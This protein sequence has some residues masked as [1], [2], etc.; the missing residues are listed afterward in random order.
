MSGGISMN[1]TIRIIA[2]VILTLLLGFAARQCGPNKTYTVTGELNG[3]KLQHTAPRTHVYAYPETAGEEKIDYAEAG[4][5]HLDVVADP[6]P[7]SPEALELELQARLKGEKEWS[8]YP[9]TGIEKREDG[10]ALCR[11][12]IPGYPWVTRFTY[13]FVHR[14][15]PAA[16]PQV[17]LAHPDG[18]RMTLR[19]RGIVPVPVTVIHVLAMFAGIFMVVWTMM[20]CISLIRGPAEA[21]EPGPHRSAWW[22]WVFMFIGGV[23]FGM[24]MNYYAFNVLW[25]AVPFGSD[26]TDNKTQVALVFWGLA[27]VFLTRRPGRHAGLFV[28][29]AG[30]LSLAMYLIPHSL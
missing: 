8:F 26:I 18:G 16:K 6:A 22:A 25:E 19:F 23:P 30:L 3:I 15:E 27:A 1:R 24:M 5:T 20:G 28:L 12:D 29:G 4:R 10:T 14:S 7:E 11:F 21:A 2:C 9:C 13:R 17:V